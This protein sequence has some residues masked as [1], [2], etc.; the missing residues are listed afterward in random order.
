[1]KISRLEVSDFGIDEGP[2]IS[3]PNIGG[4]DR[5]FI[6]GNRSGKTLTY[7]SI[8]YGLYGTDALTGISPGRRSEVKIH[9][10][11][12][13]SVDRTGR[14]H[15]YIHNGDEI[16]PETAVPEHI[17]SRDLLE[18]QFITLEDP[19]PLSDVSGEELIS[20][21]RQA[22]TSELHQ[23]IEYH[24]RAAGH[25]QRM[26][27]EAVNGQNGPSLT[28]LEEELDDLHI[29][30]DQ[31]RIE[32][33]ERLLSMLDSGELAQISERLQKEDEISQE[34]DQLYDRKRDLEQ[35]HIRPLKGDLRD[36]KRYQDEVTDILIDAVTEMNCPVCDRIVDEETASSR[37]DRRGGKKCPHCDQ[38]AGPSLA[39]VEDRI[40][41]RVES[42]DDTID[43]L[44]QELE[45]VREELERV[46]ERIEEIQERE[47]ELSNVDDFVRTA[48]KQADHDLDEVEAYAREELD[49]H[50][51]R[52]EEEK[53]L[54]TELEEKITRIEQRRD[55]L[56][57]GRDYA[58][59]LV[60]ELSDEALS[61][62]I[63]DFA[64]RWSTNYHDMA[65]E[66]AAEINLSE[67]GNI[68]LPGTDSQGARTYAELSGGERWLLNISFGYTLAE[69]THGHD[70]AHNWETLVLD[71]P[72]VELSEENLQSVVN[73]LY[74][75]DIQCMI[76][77]SDEDVQ[78]PFR[79]GEVHQL[80]QI[81]LDQATLSDFINE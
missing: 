75:S 23:K 38:E 14:P 43:E 37:L 34:L 5:V 78:G 28:E 47:S 60:E 31:D 20:D 11:N 56:A 50:H 36:A 27:S 44:E 16:D 54:K 61:E 69:S 32:K 6:G 40:A 30:S 10:D 57:K 62:V 18:Y 66:L 53:E 26:I 52:L 12:S 51:E 46:K 81:E 79:R 41:E 63:E 8:L 39:E 48:L 33:I 76:M 71:Q 55:D 4:S 29:E 64:Q 24:Q 19:L 70:T 65:P 74:N 1:M 77:T 45:S 13:D 42:A 9:F 17:G 2:E 3:R 72:F 49:K 73:F 59:D 35:N 25:C 80:S 7:Y 15:Q 21:I 68:T 67:E 58:L 22:L